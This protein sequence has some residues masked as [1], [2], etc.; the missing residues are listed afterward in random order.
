M[1]NI[2]G[3]WRR[4]KCVKAGRQSRKAE[5]AKIGF[6]RAGPGRSEWFTKYL[7]IW[8]KFIF[9]FTLVIETAKNLSSLC[10][11]GK[12]EVF[13]NASLLEVLPIFLFKTSGFYEICLSKETWRTPRTLQDHSCQCMRSVLGKNSYIISQAPGFGETWSFKKE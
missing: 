9:R 4:K 13:R 2:G 12:K 11:R 3:P 8:V 1:E 6:L 7:L 10:R 5:A